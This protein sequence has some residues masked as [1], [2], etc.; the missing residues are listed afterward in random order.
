MRLDP[1]GG[2]GWMDILLR[3]THR[4]IG[5]NRNSKMSANAMFG[6]VLQLALELTCSVETSRPLE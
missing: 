5:A 2:H 4:G 6:I 1:L 3:E